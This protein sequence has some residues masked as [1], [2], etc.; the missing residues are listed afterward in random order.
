MYCSP[1]P[2]LDL[3]GLAPVL[4]ERALTGG[5]ARGRY[6]VGPQYALSLGDFT[7][8]ALCVEC[9]ARELAAIDTHGRMAKVDG[10]FPHW[11]L[12]YEGERFSV[13]WF[14]TTGAPTPQSTAVF[15]PVA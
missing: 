12:P 4:R 10:R 11:V 3:L 14:R 1:R 7:G 13:I 9:G 5:C 2:S 6:D 15:E 8:G